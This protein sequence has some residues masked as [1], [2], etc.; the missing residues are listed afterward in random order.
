MDDDF[1]EP[2]KTQAELQTAG[3]QMRALR[4]AALSKAWNALE[5]PFPV[6]H[7]FAGPKRDKLDLRDHDFEQMVS[8]YMGLVAQNW[9]EPYLKL[10]RALQERGHISRDTSFE[11]GNDVYVWTVAD[12][13]VPQER[14]DKLDQLFAGMGIARDEAPTVYKAKAFAIETQTRNF[15][16][17]LNEKYGRWSIHMRRFWDDIREVSKNDGYFHLQ[18]FANRKDLTLEDVIKLAHQVSEHYGD[19][20]PGV[21]YPHRPLLT[22]Y[23]DGDLIA[24]SDTSGIGLRYGDF[25]DMGYVL[26]F[27]NDAERPEIDGGTVC[28][29]HEVAYLAYNIASAHDQLVE[30]DDAETSSASDLDSPQ[31]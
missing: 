28:N 3:E 20:L 2:M 8:A 27:K 12:R 16:V 17:L 22:T 6:A 24:G 18:D 25:R 21:S 30:S 19:A 29:F 31:D 4:D 23:L 13:D 11:F 9:V 7:M 26:S 15:L 14:D 1:K 5:R 10:Y